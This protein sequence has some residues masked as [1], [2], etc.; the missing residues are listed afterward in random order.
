MSKHRVDRDV[1][2]LLCRSCKLLT[3]KLYA[4][5]QSLLTLLTQELA[6]AS[7]ED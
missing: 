7:R 6:K 2:F 3:V 1:F 4:P 5:Q